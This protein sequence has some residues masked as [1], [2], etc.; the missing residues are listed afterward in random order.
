M[1]FSAR[2]FVCHRDEVNVGRI[3]ASELA[4][5]RGCVHIGILRAI[6]SLGVQRA[7]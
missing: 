5:E 1:L 6:V 3:E 7:L 4:R 2:A